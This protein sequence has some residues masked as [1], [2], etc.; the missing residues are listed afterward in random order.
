MEF[1]LAQFNA[2]AEA[3]PGFIW[4]LQ[5]S[6]GNAKDLMSTT[7]TIGPSSNRRTEFFER[8]TEPHCVLWWVPA[9]LE[10][11]AACL[12]RYRTLGPM[13]DDFWFSARQPAPDSTI[14]R[15]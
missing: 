5:A 3:S 6:S 12:E 11:A 4:R 9:G 14:A 1:Q 15:A 13:A 2:L 7:R 8:P 10:E